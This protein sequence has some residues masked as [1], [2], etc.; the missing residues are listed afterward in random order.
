MLEVTRKLD[1]KTGTYEYYLNNGKN[2]LAIGCKDNG[3]LCVWT[4]SSKEIEFNITKENMFIYSLFDEL[5][6][7][8]KQADIYCLT[9]KDLLAYEDEEEAYAMQ[10]E[11]CE[12]N[13]E[14][15]E[16]AWYHKL[17]HDDTIT[18]ISTESSPY[19]EYLNQDRKGNR[20]ILKITRQ[21]DCF[22][23]RMTSN[24]MDNTPRREIII[25]K[26]SE[27]HAPVNVL[28]MRF[29]EKLLEYDPS[30]HQIY[31]EEYL[32]ETGRQFIKKAKEKRY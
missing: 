31:I 17:F 26:C 16:S 13:Q 24:T 10:K 7:D 5:F 32:R 12:M 18:L 8:L 11:M 19:E 21:E 3:N 22:N 15:K 14:V 28:L 9:G 25:D 29:Y 1:Y 27:M 30:Y 23:I 20:H 4:L 6:S 2:L